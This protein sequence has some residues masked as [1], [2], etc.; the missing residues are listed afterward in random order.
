MLRHVAKSVPRLAARSRQ[1][2]TT[3]T[4]MW[5]HTDEVRAC[6]QPRPEPDP[7]PAALG[8]HATLALKP[9]ACR[10]RTPA[11]RHRGAQL[12]PDPNPNPIAG[13]GPRLVR[14]AAARLSLREERRH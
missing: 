5:T 3:Q 1:A 7:Q 9:P 2:S 10:G 13:A 4:I 12:E 14:A 6:H 11:Q 8:P